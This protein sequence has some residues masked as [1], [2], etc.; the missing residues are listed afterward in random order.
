M[1]WVHIH[2][3]T[4]HLPVFG[5]IIGLIILWVALV[6]RSPDLK[7]FALYYFVALGLAS[8]LVFFTGEPA[9]EA[10]EHMAGISESVIERHE[11]ASVV[12]LIMLEGVALFCLLGVFWRGRSLLRRSWYFPALLALV[13]ATT[14]AMGWV[15]NLGGKIRHSEIARVSH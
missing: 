11:E 13:V 4:N 6:W 2:L 5:T 3:M 10:I 15:A 1:N 14:L 9:E 8:L 12:G 7:S